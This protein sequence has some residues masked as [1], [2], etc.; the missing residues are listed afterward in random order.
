MKAKNIPNGNAALISGVAMLISSLIFFI[1][2]G[3]AGSAWS[4]SASKVFA[5]FVLFL[6]P[7]SI[8]FILFGASRRVKAK[9]YERY[10]GL[11]PR[12]LDLAFVAGLLE[13]P[14]ARVEKDLRA[15]L[16]KNY[17]SGYVLDVNAKRLRGPESVQPPQPAPGACVQ[18]PGG[19]INVVCSC[20][21]AP[22]E[23]I[24][25]KQ[26]DCAYCGAPLGGK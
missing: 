4:T 17:L 20:C 5:S 10:L 24:A 23:I 18:P 7:A 11:I 8:V 13:Y 1:L 2:S 12:E 26:G 25:G 21:G 3:V 6:F 16:K 19:R 14:Y 9:R 15:I 22:N